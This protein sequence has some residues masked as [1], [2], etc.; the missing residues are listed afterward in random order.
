MICYVV[1]SPG[2]TASSQPDNAD[3]P[4]TV[5]EVAIASTS[6]LPMTQSVSAQIEQIIEHN[7]NV[8]ELRQTRI[9]LASLPWER[10]QSSAASLFKP[11]QRRR[12]DSLAV[13]VTDQVVKTL[14]R[15][16]SRQGIGRRRRDLIASLFTAIFD[17]KG[18]PWVPK[19]LPLENAGLEDLELDHWHWGLFTVENIASTALDVLHRGIH[20]TALN[21]S[22]QQ[23]AELT[24][25]SELQ[26][27]REKADS[28]LFQLFS[29][30]EAD[31][32]FWKGRAEAF[33]QRFDDRA[34]ER[35]ALDS[36]QQY[37]YSH[38]YGKSALSFAVLLAEAAPHLQVVASCAATR[39]RWPDEKEKAQELQQIIDLL[40]PAG[41]GSAGILVRLL[42]VEVVQF[43]VGF[44]GRA[45]SV[46]DQVLELVEICTD[47]SDFLG[48]SAIRGRKPAGTKLHNFG[49]FYKKSW[50]ANDWMLGRL[51]GAERL[52]RIL[53]DP[54]R[55]RRLYFGQH[56]SLVCQQLETI[57]IPPPGDP[58]EQGCRTRWKQR[59]HQVTE[60]LAF[61]NGH[62]QLPEQLVHAVDAVLYR[63]QLAIL[64]EELPLI[65]SAIEDDIQDRH[66]PGKGRP[67]LN[68]MRGITVGPGSTGLRTVESDVIE[69]LYGT[70]HVDQEKISEQSTSDRFTATITRAFAVGVSMLA[71]KN[72]G[73]PRVGSLVR[74]LRFPALLTDAIAQG[75][76]Q[77]SKV[78]VFAYAAIIGASVAILLLTLSPTA[79]IPWLYL[80]GAAAA[81]ALSVGLFAGHGKHRLKLL[82][83]LFVIFIFL[84]SPEI[85]HVLSKTW[86]W[87]RG[88]VP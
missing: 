47:N 33:P 29:M 74:V 30:R 14:V 77:E 23:S 44:S 40:A 63:L 26:K 11:Y 69:N 39:K 72:V 22:D 48:V 83:L 16:G 61:L 62:T 31:G 54:D 5:A 79:H 1:P 27:I 36:V 52:V 84:A 64:R 59:S 85:R 10:V 57:A 32:G 35:W 76:L 41:A 6:T 78:G 46:V 13:Y 38:K 3:K 55:I 58:D 19:S 81:L 86:T 71:G 18:L 73:V 9:A 42:K 37:P 66:G 34:A 75:L 51:Q 87:V 7:R 68:L 28:L 49:G 21:A 88:Q 24:A 53:L 70:C 8:R 43:A 2:E 4:P 45:R 56:P 12:A 82:V 60:E 20:L 80:L 25:S 15:A 50:R 65:A 67:F 17:Q